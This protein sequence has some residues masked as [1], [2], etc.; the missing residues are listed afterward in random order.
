ME[1]GIYLTEDGS[2]SIF[3]DKF[4]ESYHSRHGA[5]QESQH[6]FINAGLDA[7]QHLEQVHI[8]EMGLGTG[9]NAFL[10]YLHI[11]NKGQKTNYLGFEAYPLSLDKIAQFNYSDQLGET[12]QQ[13]FFLQ[14]HQCAWEE[15]QQ[16]TPFFLFEKRKSLLQDALID[17]IYDVIYYDAFA[18]AAQPELWEIPIME[19]MYV[20][21]RPNGCLVTYCAKGVFKR[22]LKSVGFEVEALPGPP[23]KREMTRAWKRSH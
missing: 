23:G 8:L 12:A 14:L 10:T 18:P 11:K 17:P 4:G 3:S 19:K 5:I 13:D 22:C 6:V 15:P 9:L 1:K 2:H 7:M 21:L 16:M 20:A